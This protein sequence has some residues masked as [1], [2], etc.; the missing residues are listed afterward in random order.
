MILASTLPVR[1]GSIGGLVLLLV[2][3][4]RL[5]SYCCIGFSDCLNHFLDVHVAIPYSAEQALD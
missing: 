1:L 5:R 2:A 4:R 3:Q